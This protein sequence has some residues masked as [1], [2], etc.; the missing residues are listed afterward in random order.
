MQVNPTDEKR[1]L[2]MQQLMKANP[3][4]SRRPTAPLVL[5]VLMLYPDA[6]VELRFMRCDPEVSAM[7]F[8]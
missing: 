3:L 2:E 5:L 7:A 1:W 6:P 4:L 8:Q